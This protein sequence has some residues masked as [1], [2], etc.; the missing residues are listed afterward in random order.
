MPHN[1]NMITRCEKRQT[2]KVNLPKLT[3]TN[4]HQQTEENFANIQ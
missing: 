1:T 2:I 4:F 3:G